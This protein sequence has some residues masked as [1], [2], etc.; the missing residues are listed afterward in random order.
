[1]SAVRSWLARWLRRGAEAGGPEMPSPRWVVVD[2]ETS[3][4]DVERDRLL[5]IGAVAVDDEGI[6]LSDS[7]ETV[8]RNDGATDSANIV[9][10]GIGRESQAAGTPAP[11]ALEAFRAWADGAPLVG[12]H[13]DFDCAV[14]R[15]AAQASGVAFDGAPWLDLAPLAAGLVPGAY[16]YGG[17]TLDDW[18]AA[19]GIECTIRHNAAADAL[20]TAELLLRLRALAAKQGI[21]G[22]GALCKTARQQKWLGPSER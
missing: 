14:L 15:R 12:F 18:L 11:Q 9:V 7:F 13:A 4:L 17:N 8:V 1:M 19:F 6:R 10:H 2:T 22:F 21:R 3:G 16:R 20:A 5:A